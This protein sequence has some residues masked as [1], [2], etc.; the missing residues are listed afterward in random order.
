MRRTTLRSAA[1]ALVCAA[2]IPALPTGHGAA[3]ALPPS[4]TPTLCPTMTPAPTPTTAP[5]EIVNG[6]TAVRP[7]DPFQSTF[8]LNQSVAR[9]FTAYAVVVMPD[10]SMLDALT[11][12]PSIKPVASNIPILNAPFQYPLLSLIVPAGAPP[13]PYQVLAGLFDPAQPITKPEDA[14]LLASGPFSIV[15]AIPTPTPAPIPNVSGPWK[16]IYTVTAPPPCATPP[17]T[18]SW[19]ACVQMT[20]DGKLSGSFYTTGTEPVSGDVQ[21]TYDG[22]TATW[23]VVGG[24]G[25]TYTGT[26]N[27]EGRT[28]NGTW[29]NGPDCGGAGP[30]SGT[31]EGIIL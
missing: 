21:G 10:G 16:G 17:M 26:V 1:C 11:L 25:V 4:P 9:L 31:F 14:F 7:G 18:G 27:M 29:G 28:I 8:R 30:V 23:T 24:G 19:T 5:A 13:G 2:C 15:T 22:T 20:A 12:G 3:W 6:S